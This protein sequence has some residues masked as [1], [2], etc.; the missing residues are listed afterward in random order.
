M[1]IRP[2]LALI[3]DQRQHTIF[4][5]IPSTHLFPLT[6]VKVL[7]APTN[8]SV[9]YIKALLLIQNLQVDAVIHCN[10]CSSRTLFQYLKIKDNHGGRV[11]V[12]V[13]EGTVVLG[14]NTKN[15][16]IAHKGIQ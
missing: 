3:A 4:T 10:S 6:W 9:E 13:L 7:I 2:R 11:G 15:I 8:I 12:Y 1:L 14:K 16:T 5:S